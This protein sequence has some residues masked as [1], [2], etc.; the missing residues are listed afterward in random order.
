MLADGKLGILELGDTLDAGTDVAAF[1]LPDA[2]DD[3]SLEDGELAIEDPL[4]VGAETA[5]L[6]TL[7]DAVIDEPLDEGKLGILAGD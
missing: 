3:E 1:E 4:A 7:G 6:L 2:V 5:L